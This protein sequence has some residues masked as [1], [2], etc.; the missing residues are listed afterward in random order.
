M[1]T[2]LIVRAY[3]LRI[4]LQR[5]HTLE[6]DLE[7]LHIQGES[8][9]HDGTVVHPTDEFHGCRIDNEF[10]ELVLLMIPPSHR[11]IGLW[12]S[13]QEATAS[14]ISFIHAEG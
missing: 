12:A 8:G 3:A 2:I 4:P 14:T 5:R 1:W 6:Q 9:N 13:M 10:R 7:R 11:A